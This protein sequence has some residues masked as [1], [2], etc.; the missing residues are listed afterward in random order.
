MWFFKI[1]GSSS[2]VDTNNLR[3]IKSIYCGAEMYE[4]YNVSTDL[5]SIETYIL[6]SC[7]WFLFVIHT[8]GYLLKHKLRGFTNSQ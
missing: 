2:I 5:F 7:L 6:D 8:N 4:F 1:C 3:V